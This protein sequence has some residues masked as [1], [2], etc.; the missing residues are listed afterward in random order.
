MI[1]FG[2]VPHPRYERHIVPK[3]WEGAGFDRVAPRKPVGLCMH[4]W[5]GFG[6]KLALVRLFGTGGERQGDALTDYSLTQEGEL[7][8]LN[9]PEGTR[10]PW[11]NGAADH[12]EGDGPLFVR[13]LGVSAVNARLLSVEFEGK[14]EPLTRLQMEV[15][16]SLWAHW[17]DR[18]KVPWNEYPNNPHVGCVTDLDHWEFASKECPF[19][20]ARSQR[21]MFQDMVRGKMRSAQ[22]GGSPSPI[23]SPNPPAPDH[24]WLPDG[25]TERAVRSMFGQGTRHNADGSTTMFGFDQKGIISNA[26]LARGAKDKQ[27]PP[28]G[29]WWV[30]QDT[31]TTAGNRHIVTFRNGWVLFGESDNRATWKWM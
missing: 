15:G 30:V 11:A 25:L 3:P 21:T 29:D 19:A 17:F 12:L 20:G 22:E 27:Y 9:E 7:V 8:L 24:D 26:W 1:T 23:P 28:A 31:T 10:S 13:K 18:V 5:W 4:K 14:D 2:N 6:D 16:S